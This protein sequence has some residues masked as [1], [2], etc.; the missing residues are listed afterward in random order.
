MENRVSP[1]CCNTIHAIFLRQ[2]LAVRCHQ[3]SGTANSKCTCIRT[4]FSYRWKY[5]KGNGLPF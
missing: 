5:S 3:L 2:S 4:F 1:L